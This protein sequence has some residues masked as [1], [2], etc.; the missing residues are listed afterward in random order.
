M[1]YWENGEKQRAANILDKGKSNKNTYKPNAMNYTSEIPDVP[2]TNEEATKF[3]QELMGNDKWT[4]E[5]SLRNIDTNSIS[6]EVRLDGE[7]KFIVEIEL[8]NSKDQREQDF[9]STFKLNGYEDA[10]RNGA[11]HLAPENI[12]EK[13]TSKEDIPPKVQE[14]IDKADANTVSIQL[15][16]ENKSDVIVI[17]NWLDVNDY[18]IGLII[19][20]IYEKCKH[21]KFLD[22][23]QN[24]WLTDIPENINK[25]EKLEKLSLVNTQVGFDKL[26][27]IQ[28]KSNMIFNMPGS[29]HLNYIYKK[30]HNNN[31]EQWLY[32]GIGD[33]Q[34]GG[35]Y[36]Y[37]MHTNK[38]E[39]V[40]ACGFGRFILGDGSKIYVHPPR[41]KNNLLSYEIRDGWNSNYWNSN[42]PEIIH[43]PDGETELTLSLHH[44]D[45]MKEIAI[46]SGFAEQQDIGAE[47]SKD[48]KNEEIQQI[49]SS[50]EKK[51]GHIYT[52]LY[53]HWEEFWW[54]NINKEA[55]NNLVELAKAADKDW[56]RIE[57]TSWYRDTKRQTEAFFWDD[58]ILH[59]FPNDD[60]LENNLTKKERHTIEKDYLKRS[61]VVAPPW[62]SEHHTE[63]AFDFGWGESGRLS[64]QSKEFKWLQENAWI[65]GFKLS[66]PDPKS[67]RYEP[68]HWLYIW[69]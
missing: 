39:I 32:I 54:K 6:Y 30:I 63:K 22:L 18:N 15:R 14:V 35:Y 49:T 29:G 36:Y 26:E 12:T 55:W 48:R 47:N 61:T 13:E 10:I 28:N 19:E 53:S 51:E 66:Y 17:E 27:K 33:K 24:R 42:K 23:G 69:K 46:K 7:K 56:L 9:I 8:S 57:M 2:P 21:L 58:A 62:Y 11:T 41:N 50:T 59:H 37:S 60:I 65:Y 4:A 45:F 43:L 52:Y 20:K 67:P 44:M 5:I 1:E 16:E 31:T 25:F 68:W 38:G 3:V 64:D 34:E 40:N